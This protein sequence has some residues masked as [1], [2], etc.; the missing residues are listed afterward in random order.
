MKLE[1]Y[2]RRATGGLIGSKRLEIREELTAHLLERAHKYEI[3]GLTH[4]G[5]LTRA[6][7]ELGDAQ[8]IRA[9][10]IGVHMIPQVSRMLIFIGL[11]TAF[12]LSLSP[13][14][15]RADV[16]FD[17]KGPVK[18]C[19]VCMGDASSNGLIWFNLNSL[20][21]AFGAAG[22]KV[23]R[24]TSEYRVR[25]DGKDIVLKPSY[26][27]DGNDFIVDWRLSNAIFKSNLPWRVSGWHE[28]ELSINSTRVEIPAQNNLVPL[29]FMYREVTSE[30][31]TNDLKSSS[32]GWYSAPSRTDTNEHVIQTGKAPGTVV[33]LIARQANGVPIFDL[34]PVRADGSVRLRGWYDKLR[35]VTRA[36]SIS[37]YASQGRR[38]AIMLALTGKMGFLPN[39]RRSRY[40]L[41]VPRQQNSDASK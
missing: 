16:Q 3:A 7:E 18:L 29:I 13:P 38:N 39:D 5:A 14:L 36:D 12:A 19:K 34:A 27:R 37:P 31:V 10:M 32:L 11:A 26:T 23:S 30:F 33:A 9:G 28:G 2:L 25:I 17:G 21:K 6:I 1:T 8:T 24:T 4:Q 41:F 20:T 35:F 15:A 22:A 40:E